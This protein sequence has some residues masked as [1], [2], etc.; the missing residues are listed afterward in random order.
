M[1]IVC[2]MNSNLIHILTPGSLRVNFAIIPGTMGLFTFEG[3]TRGHVREVTLGSRAS[4]GH[5]SLLCVCRDSQTPDI[6]SPGDQGRSCVTCV[7]GLIIIGLLI[8]PA[9]EHSWDTVN[10]PV[11]YFHLSRSNLHQTEFK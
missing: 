1:V 6:V 5:Y 10:M 2:E 7:T 4:L 3:G 9:W 8:G 11:I